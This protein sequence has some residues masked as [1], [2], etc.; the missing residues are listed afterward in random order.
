MTKKYQVVIDD[1]S[2]NELAEKFLH[3][4]Y[5]D[6]VIAG[7][8]EVVPAFS[9]LV[10][11]D[12]DSKGVTWELDYK[13]QADNLANRL[14]ALLKSRKAEPS[15]ELISIFNR[16]SWYYVAAQDATG[17]LIKFKAQGVKSI[18]KLLGS[19]NVHHTS[20]APCVF[21]VGLDSIVH[22]ITD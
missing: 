6:H 9:N 4:I 5:G 12:P 21:S 3:V 16:G 22:D 14:N 10:E 11:S 1:Y 18:N 8:Q 17:K 7:P 2:L 20:G 15:K 13:G 19:F